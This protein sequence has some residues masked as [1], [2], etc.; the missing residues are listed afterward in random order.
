MADGDP[1]ARSAAYYDAL[2]GF[3]DDEKADRRLLNS[4]RREHPGARS[5]PDVGCG[6]GRTIA[7]LSPHYA[8][9]GADISRSPA[10]SR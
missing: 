4:L 5:V 8:V 1:Y 9:A 2:Y 7:S 3:V 6:T 10:P